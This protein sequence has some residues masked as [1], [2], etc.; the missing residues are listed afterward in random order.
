MFYGS[1]HRAS[2][3]LTIGRR[4][5]FWRRHFTR[6]RHLRMEPSGETRGA[7]EK[8]G[9]DMCGEA[10][11]LLTILQLSDSTFPI[12]GFAHSNGYEAYL[13]NGLLRDVEA[14]AG[15]C[16]EI[17]SNAATL[18]MPFVSASHTV[19]SS[20]VNDDATFDEDEKT[21][22]ESELLKRIAA[23]DRRL[24]ASLHNQV[25]ARASVRQGKGL[26]SIVS[27]M[28]PPE[29]Q[30]EK[31]SACPET[32]LSASFGSQIGAP[33]SSSSYYSSSSSSC[34]SSSP[35][36][37]APSFSEASKTCVQSE[38]RRGRVLGRMRKWCEG[39]VAGMRGHFACVFGTVCALL[40]VSLE[41]SQ[42]AFLFALL[43]TTLTAAVR[44]GSLI[45]AT[46]AQVLLYSS[47]RRIQELVRRYGQLGCE[48]AH[49]RF[50][51]PEIS[52]ST[53]ELFFSKLF[54]S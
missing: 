35:P 41:T 6:T 17:L 31:L 29:L 38:R 45:S 2:S 18:Q 48:E 52:H 34:S 15:F 36:V 10:G 46:Q 23:L 14:F 26:V 51:L 22:Q 19:C 8:H 50:P 43:R 37:V 20:Q 25:A 11:E 21:H 30:Q 4:V 3:K 24:S 53:H 13:K 9:V 47:H 1:F 5:D 40:N 28:F 7:A 54:T 12:S 27:D 16:E 32:C 39:N 49:I 33:P 44:E 42:K